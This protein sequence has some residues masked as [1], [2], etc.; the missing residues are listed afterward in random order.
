MKKSVY[1]TMRKILENRL[2]RGFVINAFHLIWYHSKETWVKNTFLGYPIQ[3]CPFDMH[4]YQEIIH[5]VRPSFVI[6]TGVAGGGS[7]L[8]FASLLDLIGAPPEAVVVGIDLELTQSACSLAHP[9][10]RLLEGSS[11][12]PMVVDRIRPLLTGSKGFVSL[13]SDHRKE[14]VLSELLA[15]REFVGLDS[16]MVVEDTNIGGHPVQTPSGLEPGP[17]EAVTEF[18]AS[19]S[20]FVQDNGIWQ[21]TLFSHHQGGWLKRSH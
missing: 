2:V 5:R 21:R 19:D 9:R 4:L 8:Y 10:I 14:H 12:D 18:L 3:Q 7:L 15:Y 20:R 16:Y 11:V 13:D 17:L 6:Q 1:K